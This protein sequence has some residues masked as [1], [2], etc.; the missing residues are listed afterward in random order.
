VLI[1]GHR[2]RLESALPD[3]AIAVVVTVISAN[4]AGHQ[5]L[6][7]STQIAIIPWPHDQV[8]V[9]GHQNVAQHLH[10]KSF[11]SRSN[12]RF[13]RLEIAGLVKHGGSSV[14]TIEDMVNNAASGGSG[15]ARHGA[16]LSQ[17]RAGVKK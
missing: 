16:T 12:Q 9:I 8:E 2:E 7:P 13:K 15:R 3:V 10:G 6:H 5:P 11:T 17:S 1:G 4:M 14:A